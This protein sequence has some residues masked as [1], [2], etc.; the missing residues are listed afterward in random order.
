MACWTMRTGT[1]WLCRILSL[2]GQWLALWE[3]GRQMQTWVRCPDGW[4]VVAAHVSVIDDP[5]GAD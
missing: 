3:I 1:R 5:G 2:I 4:H